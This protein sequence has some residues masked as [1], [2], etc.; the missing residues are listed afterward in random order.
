MLL[1]RSLAFLYDLLLLLSVF[2][3]V[4]GVAVS[5]NDGEA[6]D[7]D[8]FDVLPYMAALYLSAFA[9][10]YG[11]W[12]HGGQTL[13]M[14][15]WRLRLVDDN[16]QPPSPRHCVCRFVGGTLL[17]GASW[18]GALFTRDRLPLHDRLSGTRIVKMPKPDH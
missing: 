6:I 16:G 12:R 11:F 13:G 7:H 8:S 2:F 5:L 1:R 9:F 18:V 14:K 3:V 17:F 15:A 10:Y 4:T